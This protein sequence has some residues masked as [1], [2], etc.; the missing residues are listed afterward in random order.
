MSFLTRVDVQLKSDRWG[1]AV[2]SQAN[3]HQLQGG[4]VNRIYKKQGFLAEKRKS[5]SCSGLK[6]ALSYRLHFLLLPFSVWF[7]LWNVSWLTHFLD[8]T[9]IKAHYCF[10][11][12]FMEVQHKT[13]HFYVF[14]FSFTTL[15]LFWIGH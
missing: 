9:Q 4:N 2:P 14:R 6:S 8:Y 10:F 15:T 11:T 1:L 3:I 7:V 13:H 12:V 5:F